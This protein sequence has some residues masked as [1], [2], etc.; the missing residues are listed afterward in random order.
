MKIKS[1]GVDLEIDA[2]YA[3]MLGRMD[4]AI[5]ATVAI[6]ITDPRIAAGGLLGCSI[7]MLIEHLQCN[8]RQV[9]A[10]V[11]DWFSNNSDIRAAL[12]RLNM[13][14]VPPPPPDGPKGSGE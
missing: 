9:H 7:S 12:A 11:T 14:A 2:E 4:R 3:G 8:E 10:M 6:L 13:H 5:R 1:G